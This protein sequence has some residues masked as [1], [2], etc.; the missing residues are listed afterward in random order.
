MT[1]LTANDIAAYQAAHS[2][3]QYPTH[4]QTCN[5]RHP[6]EVRM[7]LDEL[8]EE[9]ARLAAAEKVIE[10]ARIVDRD[11]AEGH[12]QLGQA[13]AAYDTAKRGEEK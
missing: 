11:G 9:R 8:A 2:P 10:A 12:A 6:C 3:G 5:L 4:C 13:L 7:I 1:R